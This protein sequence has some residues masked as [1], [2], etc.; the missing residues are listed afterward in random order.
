MVLVKMVA[1]VAHKQCLLQSL[2]CK[3][4][5][6]DIF[7]HWEL[8][9]AL[10]KENQELGLIIDLTFTSRYYNIQVLDFKLISVSPHFPS[11]TEESKRA[12]LCS[13]RRCVGR[14]G[15]AGVSEDL[16]EG[17]RSPK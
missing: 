16:H 2:H 17:A 8:L 5:P 9:D 7:G 3:L 12:A 13:L 4:R 14:T 6:P 10:D 11:S 1:P 15:V